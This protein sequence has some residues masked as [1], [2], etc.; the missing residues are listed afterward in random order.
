LDKGKRKRGERE[1]EKALPLDRGEGRAR[2][3]RIPVTI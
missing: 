2:G 1:G 3:P